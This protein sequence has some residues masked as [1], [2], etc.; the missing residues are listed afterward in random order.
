M[1]RLTPPSATP[2]ARSGQRAPHTLHELV[3]AQAVRSPRAVAVRSHDGRSTTYATLLERAHALADRLLDYGVEPGAHVGVMMHRVPDLVPT[4]LAVSLTGAAYVPLE[5]S[6]PA[7]RLRTIVSDASLSLVVHSEDV[8]VPALP[9]VRTTTLP[10]DGGGTAPA[11]HVTDRS[12]PQG[13]GTAYVMYTSGTTGRPKGVVVPQTSVTAFLHALGDAFPLDGTDRV[14]VRTPFTFDVSVMDMFWPLSRG[15]S[16]VFP[17]PQ[18]HLDPAH[19]TEVVAGHGVTAATF[20]PTQLNAFLAA[21][22]VSDCRS[23]RRVF[24]MG[25]ALHPVTVAALWCAL[26]GV[27]L[28]NAYGPTEATVVTV[29]HRCRP[30][31]PSRARVPIG[32]PLGQTGV[33]I[34]DP[35]TLRP[36]P[37]GTPGELIL[38]GP[39]ITRGYLGQPEQTRR[40]FLPDTFSAHADTTDLAYRTGD[41]VVELPDGELDHLGREDRQVKIRGNRI[42]LGDVEHALL[43]LPRVV[44]ARA[45][46]RAPGPG[47]P[48]TLT[49]WVVVAPGTPDTGTELRRALLRTVPTAMVP[50]HIAVLDALPTLTS[51][52]LDSAR[53]PDPCDPAGQQS[54]VSRVKKIWADV[55]GHDDFTDDDTFFEAGGNSL[56][57]LRVRARLAQEGHPGI[58]VLDLLDHPTPFLLAAHLSRRTSPEDLS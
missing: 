2:R 45:E 9:G 43:D 8:A 24:S 30:G 46:L 54:A 15:A 27:E 7:E 6:W 5:P 47:G 19:L 10:E 57:L 55:L 48:A 23:L 29:L 18:G 1:M 4:L 16:L 40:Q 58:R 38:T 37:S 28:V 36:V 53:L 32:R 17:H 49:A 39:Q 42:E 51:G 11:P 31:D 35:R 44:D 14:L 41:T 13:A 26:P 3:T 22:A 50:D 34:V 12:A 56:L 20:V 33:H 21:P 52:K 25:E